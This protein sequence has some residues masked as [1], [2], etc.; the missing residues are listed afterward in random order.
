MSILVLLSA[1]ARAFTSFSRQRF[2]TFHLLQHTLRCGAL[3][4]SEIQFANATGTSS[5]AAQPNPVQ[6]LVSR[7]GIGACVKHEWRNV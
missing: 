7:A 1:G 4:R 3:Q 5:S 2:P 6:L